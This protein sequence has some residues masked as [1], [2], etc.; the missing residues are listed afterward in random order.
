EQTQVQAFL[1][2]LAPHIGIRTIAAI[3]VPD[4]GG[5]IPVTVEDPGGDERPVP[6]LHQG[7]EVEGLAFARVTV[8]Q[9]GAALAPDAANAL[10]HH[11]LAG[12]VPH[13]DDLAG[14]ERVERT[15]VARGVAH[16]HEGLGRLGEDVLDRRA[17]LAGVGPARG[18]AAPDGRDAP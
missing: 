18:L 15:R 12:R 4:A 11:L 8:A 5:E 10:A 1:A 16:L 2:E 13:P 14:D 6:V 3:L 9:H 7:L 17:D